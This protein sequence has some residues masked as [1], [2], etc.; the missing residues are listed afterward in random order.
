MARFWEEIELRVDDSH[1]NAPSPKLQLPETN[2]F[3][4]LAMQRSAEIKSQ[5]DRS[6]NSDVPAP[7]EAAR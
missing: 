6:T 2:F 1:S 4:H 7:Q 3:Y 5:G